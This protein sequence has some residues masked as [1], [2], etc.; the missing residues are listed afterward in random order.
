MINNQ[1]KTVVLLGSLTGLLLLI[2]SFFGQNGLTIAIIFA[3]LMNIGSYF[4]ADKL[5]LMMYRAKKIEQKDNPDLFKL[6]REVVQLAHIPMPKIYIIPTMTPNAF[7]TGRSPK[8]ATVAFTEGI[9]KLLNK[10]ELKG[11]IAHEISHVKN[12]DILIQTI[13]S[14]IAGV[15]SYIAFMARWAA[16]FGGNRDRDSGNLF[17]LLALAI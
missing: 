11:V 17:E 6:V 4:F 14:T 13:A 9:L 2:G 16:I 8:Y 10:D 5:V 12:R 1:L 7:A 3:V 15:I